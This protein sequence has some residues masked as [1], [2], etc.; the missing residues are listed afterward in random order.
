MGKLVTELEAGEE[1]VFGP[2]TFTK[3]TSLSGGAGPS[4]GS[5]STTGGRTVGVTNR[6]IIIE[7]LK[8]P[9]RAQIIPNDQVQRVFIKRKQRAGQETLSITKVETAAGGT[10]KVDLPGISASKEALLKQTFPNAEIGAPQ[11]LSK[12]AWIA[13]AVVVG[14][15]ALCCII[16]VAAPAI[17]NLLGK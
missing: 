17:A 11:G 2:V 10:V 6:R 8:A 9:E 12:G 1:I 14:L 4:Q 7:D 5:V 16:F 13:I 15:A 3:T